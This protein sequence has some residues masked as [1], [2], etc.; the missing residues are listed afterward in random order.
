M[1]LESSDIIPF[2]RSELHLTAKQ[3]TLLQRQRSMIKDLL[4]TPTFYFSYTYDLTN[5]QQ[6]HASF[7]YAVQHRNKNSFNSNNNHY[8]APSNS[9]STVHSKFAWNYNI[10]RPFLAKVDHLFYC[11]AVIHGAVFIQHCS[12]NGKHFRWSLISRRSTKRAGTRFFRRGCDSSGYVANFV[13]TEQICEHGEYGLTSFVQTR[14]S[15]PMYWIQEPDPLIY[16][17]VPQIEVG[18]DHT[19]A[20]AAHFKEQI[21][22]Y[23]EQTVVNLVNHTKSEGALQRAYQSL[24]KESGIKEI[25]YEAFDFHKECSKFQWDNLQH[26]ISR[27]RNTLERFGYF[28]RSMDQMLDNHRNTTLPASGSTNIETQ[29]GVFRTNCMDC[30]DRTNV[31]QSMLANENL[32]RVLCKFGVLKCEFETTEAHPEFQRLFRATWADHAN[33]LAI[34]YAGS[35]ALKTDFTRTGQRTYKGL[36]EDLRN[37]IHRFFKNNFQDGFRQDSI[38]LFLGTV[39]IPMDNVGSGDLEKSEKQKWIYYLPLVLMTNL[40]ILLLTYLLSPSFVGPD[41]EVDTILFV[42][43]LTALAIFLGSVIRRKSHIYLDRPKFS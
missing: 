38:D 5:S 24:C 12:I 1:S 11:I 10:L 21:Q 31:V 17:P 28:Y 13:E 6:R 7:H 30:L 18:V 33:L 42:I 8:R 41:A 37:A 22:Y 36:L 40:S 19:A 32:N 26:L 9:I 39:S 29:L 25:V 34:Q 4:Q 43:F 15:I 3:Q 16:L 27:L 20:F 2:S 35:G 23:G 14:G